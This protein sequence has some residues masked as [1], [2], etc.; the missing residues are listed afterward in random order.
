M[1]H[2]GRLHRLPEEI[3]RFP[4]R[5]PERLWWFDGQGGTVFAGDW[6]VLE[7]GIVIIT[8]HYC[9]YLYVFFSKI[10]LWLICFVMT[11]CVLGLLE[12][13]ELWWICWDMLKISLQWHCHESLMV[14]IP[15]MLS[16]TVK[17]RPIQPVE[18]PCVFFLTGLIF[19]WINVW[20]SV[21]FCHAG[22]ENMLCWWFILSLVFPIKL[23]VMFDHIPFYTQYSWHYITYSISFHYIPVNI[24]ILSWLKSPYVAQAL[25][26][27]SCFCPFGGCSACRG[28][29]AEA[30]QQ[31]H[32]DGNSGGVTNKKTSNIKKKSTSSTIIG[33]SI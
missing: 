24:L 31:D 14:S 9:I 25:T 30:W 27:P 4:R 19:S 8:Y 26:N 12:L 22:Y 18:L 21:D 10:L 33:I 20:K 2:R 5:H 6:N 23:V 29:Q 13:N 1:K 7:W 15:R 11:F 32:P 16:S 17:K 28:E 3:H